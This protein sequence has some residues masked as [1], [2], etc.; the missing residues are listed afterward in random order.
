MAL[1]KSKEISTLAS[2]TSTA[3]L[4]ADKKLHNVMVSP[5]CGRAVPSAEKEGTVVKLRY[6]IYNVS[7]RRHIFQWASKEGMFMISLLLH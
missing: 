2:R 3:T 4:C 5:V 7:N 6:L 1:K